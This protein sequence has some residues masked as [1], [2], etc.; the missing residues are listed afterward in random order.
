VTGA[1]HGGEEGFE[2]AFDSLFPRAYHLARR[3][4]GDPAAAEDVA[5]EAL[6]R[7]YARWGRLA[8]LPH[9]DGWVLRVAS[10]LAVDELRRRS[11]RQQPPPV[12]PGADEVVTLRLALAAALG[13]L[14]RRQRESIAL[15]YFG[16]L[17]EAEVAAALGISMGSV[18][19]HV[20]R[21]MAALRARLGPD[22]EEVVPV[23]LER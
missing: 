22:A 21:G 8:G 3:V 4:L 17:T 2:Q 19:T 13:S 14:P 1:G 12:A 5:A 16:G 11:R 10:N 9:R 20:H 6:A 15:R 7:A 18:K 23:G